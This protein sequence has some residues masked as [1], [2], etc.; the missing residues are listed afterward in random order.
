MQ[1]EKQKGASRENSL[2]HQLRLLPRSCPIRPSLNVTFANKLTHA[3]VE[4]FEGKTAVSS[5][6]KSFNLSAKCGS[7]LHSFL[8]PIV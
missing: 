4:Y 7:V 5:Q 2:S 6:H 1:T 3:S 8:H